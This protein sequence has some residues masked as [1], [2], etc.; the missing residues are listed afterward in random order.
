MKKLA[1]FLLIFATLFAC[2]CSN[3]AQKT[4]SATVATEIADTMTV[5]E[6]TTDNI[7]DHY[8]E[9]AKDLGAYVLEGDSESLVVF[10]KPYQA[11]CTSTAEIDGDD[12]NIYY[13]V[14]KAKKE[15]ENSSVLYK[16][17]YFVDTKNNK[18][19]T[20]HIFENGEE[21]P[22]NSVIIGDNQPL[23]K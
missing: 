14:A 17:A 18:D 15:F 6:I 21:I 11:K 2:S 20:L 5:Q 4:E 7:S 1:V 8:L 10:V 19:A 13:Q 22:V 23:F 3:G 9:K 16:T 12:I